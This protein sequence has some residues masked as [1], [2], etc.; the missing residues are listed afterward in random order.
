MTFGQYLK[1]ERM[2]SGLSQ[3]DFAK[4]IGI[5]NVQMSYFETGKR[6]PN[7]KTMLKL[8][9]ELN[10]DRNAIEKFVISHFFGG[11]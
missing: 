6:F 10:L 5:V 1:R 7:R 9:K 4:K 2:R 8:E 3:R 11:K